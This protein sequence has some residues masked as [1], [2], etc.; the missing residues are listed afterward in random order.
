ML[1]GLDVDVSSPPATPVAIH[2]TQWNGSAWSAP[3][4]VGTVSNS[5]PFELAAAPDRFGGVWLFYSNGQLSLTGRYLA[6]GASAGDER[7][8]AQTTGLRNRPGT[9]ADPQSN[10]QVLFHLGD[11][12]FLQRLMLVTRAEVRRLF[13]SKGETPQMSHLHVRKHQSLHLCS[14]GTGNLAVAVPTS[15]HGA[16]DRERI[17]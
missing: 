10:I 12:D 11:T 9:V 6:A 5:G 17:A 15:C 13:S 16:G 1:F 4:Q 7:V 2:R 3:V 14:R 8:L